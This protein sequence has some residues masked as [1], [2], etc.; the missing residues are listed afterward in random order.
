VEKMKVVFRKSISNKTLDGREEIE[1][2]KSFILL[3]AH[4]LAT[5]KR[6][7]KKEGYRY[8]YF[9]NPMSHKNFRGNTYMWQLDR[10]DTEE[11]IIYTL[12]YAYVGKRA[13][14]IN[15]VLEFARI[16]WQ[17]S[18]EKELALLY[19][20]TGEWIL[21]HEALESLKL[22]L[23]EY[24]TS[25][26]KEWGMKWHEILKPCWRVD[27]LQSVE[28][29]EGEYYNYY[30]PYELDSLPVLGDEDI[31]ND[32]EKCAVIYDLIARKPRAVVPYS[33]VYSENSPWWV[34]EQL[35]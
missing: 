22:E 34:E 33:N 11:S 14:F 15:G 6:G 23:Y 4:D 12:T 13:S 16:N 7:L 30:T 28:T 21:D 35:R 18:S 25:T 8:I 24:H 19:N 5:S 1:A 2:M 3:V 27:T 31:K 29:S 32:T 9:T 10:R 17:R 20:P 26:P